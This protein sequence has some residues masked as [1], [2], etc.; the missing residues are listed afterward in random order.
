[1]TTPEGK[2][3]DALKRMLNK[4]RPR[5]K[6]HMPVQNG[7][8]EMTL[9]INACVDGYYFIIEVKADETAK[10]TKRQIETMKSYAEA[11]AFVFLVRTKADIVVVEEYIKL[12]LL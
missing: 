1:M 11:R 10:P 9:D 7:M 12:I 5:V 8:G 3:K 2:V 6:Y 4:Y